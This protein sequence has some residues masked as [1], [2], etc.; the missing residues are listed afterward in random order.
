MFQ[1]VL[2]KYQ[3]AFAA[4]R[5]LNLVARLRHLV[6]KSGLRRIN[7]AYSTI[8]LKDISEQ[9]GIPDSDIEFIVST[10]NSDRVIEATVNHEAGTMSSKALEDVYTTYDP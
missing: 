4:D 8:H 7:I 2:D 1:Q 9:L 3:G 10:A 5:N 6:I